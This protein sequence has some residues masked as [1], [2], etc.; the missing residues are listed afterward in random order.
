VSVLFPHQHAFYIPVMHMTPLVGHMFHI[1]F[2]RE[3]L[4]CLLPSLVL[5]RDGLSDMC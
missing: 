5:S 4:S 1:V 3:L 2:A